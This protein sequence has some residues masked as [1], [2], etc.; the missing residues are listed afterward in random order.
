MHEHDQIGRRYMEPIPLA[1]PSIG[2]GL[3][4]HALPLIPRKGLDRLRPPKQ[5][6][7]LG[8]TFSESAK[9]QLNNSAGTGKAQPPAIERNGAGHWR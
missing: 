6:F 4:R 8:W 3:A 7:V 2:P 9:K 5:P 1:V